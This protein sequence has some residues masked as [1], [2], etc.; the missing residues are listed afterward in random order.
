MSK[1][2]Y[3]ALGYLIGVA[4]VTGFWLL[5][6]KV[7]VTETCEPFSVVTTVNP[8]FGYIGSIELCGDNLEWGPMTR[9][10]AWN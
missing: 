4:L 7:G 2:N 9:E 5:S 3:A 6:D 1:W 8:G 10:G